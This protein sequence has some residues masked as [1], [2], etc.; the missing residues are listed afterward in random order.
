MNEELKFYCS[1]CLA[2]AVLLK[3][4][5][6]V[7]ELYPPG[8]APFKTGVHCSLCGDKGEPT[9]AYFPHE[10][11]DKIL[12]ESESQ[13][14]RFHVQGNA[15]DRTKHL[16]SHEMHLQEAAKERMNFIEASIMP[17][18]FCPMCGS[19]VFVDEGDYW[20]C[21]KERGPC[22]MVD[23]CKTITAVEMKNKFGIAK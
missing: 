22:T 5:R 9:E 23:L 6:N 11:M 13:T 2:K 20:R 15:D 17:H 19:R 3:K 7:D 1:G 12:E 16:L 8:K 10:D 4:I 18:S 21:T 14:E